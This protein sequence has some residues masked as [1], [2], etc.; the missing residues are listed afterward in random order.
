MRSIRL[1][2]VAATFAMA[3]TTISDT[4]S[5]QVVAFNSTGFDNEYN[6]ATA[7]FGG[8][9]HTSVMGPTI[10]AGIAIP[11]AT[12]DPLVLNWSGG[13]Y[14]EDRNGDRVYFSGGGKVFLTPLGGTRF[15]ATWKA[16]FDI[17]GGTGR[18]E[19]AGPAN[20]PLDVTAINQPFDM[21][22]DPLWFYDYKI[23]GK[24]DLGGK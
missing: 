4:A 6:P 7:T 12:D 16:K 8:T 2:L 5:A 24:I 13:G 15:T 18:Y 22:T 19:N 9:G 21:A 20:E 17:L 23:K 1:L 10:G 3:V 11:E 14:F